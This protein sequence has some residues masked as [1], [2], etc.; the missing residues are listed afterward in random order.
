MAE[1][2]EWGVVAL[3]SPRSSPAPSD[4]HTVGHCGLVIPVNSGAK[5]LAA[6]RWA[7]SSR[8]RTGVSPLA[9][10][11]SDGR[12]PKVPIMLASTGAKMEGWKK[13]Q[14]LCSP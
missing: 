13:N 5:C 7:D 12:A 6:P 9:I 8:V 2:P 14:R 11:L 10:S 1:A 3:D 4:C